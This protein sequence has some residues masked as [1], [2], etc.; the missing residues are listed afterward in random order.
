M[1]WDT[2]LAL[3][4]A[5]LLPVALLAASGPLRAGEPEEPAPKPEGIY[6]NRRMFG[7][8]QAP[9]GAG[10]TNRHAESAAM[11]GLVWLALAQEQDGRWD[12]KRWGGS[13]N[14]DVGVTG[15]ALL[16]FLGAGYTHTKGKF[17]TTLENGLRWLSTNQKDDGSFRWNTFYEQGIATMAVSEAHALTRS[18][19]SARRAQMAIDYI[20]KV[21]PDHGGFRYGGAVPKDE[22]DLS[23]SS[24]QLMALKTAL[25]AGLKVPDQAIE[26]SR[27]LLKN[28]LRERGGSAYLVSTPNPT[29]A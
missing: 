27:L 3:P 6:A 20:C 16:A 2:R 14:F 12:C 17:M 22:G 24:W 23:V 15:L 4:A 28:T 21:Q 18:P 10:G 8:G 7:T 29:P 13:G 11:A 5:W 26:R 25:A 1:R 19:F 9:G